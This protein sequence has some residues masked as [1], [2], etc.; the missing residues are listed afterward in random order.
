GEPLAEDPDGQRHR[1]RGSPGRIP[2][3]QPGHAFAGLPR[4]LDG[5]GDRLAGAAAML[6]QDPSRLGQLDAA[7]ADQQL[8]T[9]L[10]PHGEALLAE[11]R[12]ADLEALGR[13]AEVQLLGHGDEVAKLPELHPRLLVLPT[14]TNPTLDG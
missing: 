1:R 11:R 2:Y 5:V 10:A 8:D 3:P 9:E 13:P 4:R 14:W 7:A 6:E 12:P